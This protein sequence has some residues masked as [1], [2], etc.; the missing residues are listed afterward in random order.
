MLS[1]RLFN[2]AKRLVPKIS[3]TERIALTCGTI[4]FDREIFSG[5]P[6]FENLMKYEVSLSKEEDKFLNHTLEDIC[7]KA[8]DYQIMKTQ[9]IQNDNMDRLKKSG[10]FGMLIPS[11]MGSKLELS[12]MHK[13]CK[14]LVS[15]KY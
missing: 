4:G 13:P 6:N 14:R 2:Y 12:S 9:N 5:R 1:T 7:S 8:N 10:I 15:F 3:E 11:E